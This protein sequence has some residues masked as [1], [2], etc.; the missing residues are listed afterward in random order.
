MKVNK[1]Y[2]GVK[3]F[4]SDISLRLCIYSPPLLGKEQGLLVALSIY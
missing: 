3:N 4:Q 2:V 1:N